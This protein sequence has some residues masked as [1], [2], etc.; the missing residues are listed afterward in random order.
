MIDYE[1]LNIII[2]FGNKMRTSHYHSSFARYESQSNELPRYD[3]YQLNHYKIIPKKPIIFSIESHR[4][5]S[6]E[7][8][9]K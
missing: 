9:S 6:A 7:I 3:S 8:K 5:K 4:H 2:R 1:G